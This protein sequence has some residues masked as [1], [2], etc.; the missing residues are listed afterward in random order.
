MEE[1]A[2]QRGS[3]WGELRTFATGLTKADISLTSQIV[4]SDEVKATYSDFGSD[5]IS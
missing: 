4:K 3:V 1:K 5:L 2:T